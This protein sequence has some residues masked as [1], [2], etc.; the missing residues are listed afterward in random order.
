MVG[1]T[2]RELRAAQRGSGLEVIEA[3][4]KDPRLDNILF[5]YTLYIDAVVAL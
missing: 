3:I 5:Y 1:C 4:G 2:S